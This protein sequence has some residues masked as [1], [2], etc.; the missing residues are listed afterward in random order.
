M[1]LPLQI[2]TRNFHL[3]EPV[4]ATI[5]DRAAKLDNYCSEIMKCRLTIEVPH[6]HKQKGI[7]Y[8]L[9]IDITVPGSEIVVKREPNTDLNI[10]IRDAFA[11]AERQLKQYSGRRQGEVK[12]HEETPT[13]RVRVLFPEED[14]GFLAAADGHE[15]YFHRNSVLN[16]KFDQLQV[17]TE[18]RVV[19]AMG[20]QGVQASTVEIL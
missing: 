16:N 19:E 1:K 7:L 6:R 9:K 8:E 13:A 4:E 5:R 3:T 10:A 18:V 2:T 20:D 15:I 11:A 17:G 14:Y 12:F